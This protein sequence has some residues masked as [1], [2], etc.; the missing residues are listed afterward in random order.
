[1]AS[2]GW[3]ALEA[4]PLASFALLPRNVTAVVGSVPTESVSAAD[5]GA[6]GS[7]FL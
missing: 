2:S 7:T 6:V 3:R 4:S 1:M 5:L